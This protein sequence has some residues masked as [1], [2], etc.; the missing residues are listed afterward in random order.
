MVKGYVK[1]LV[2][3]E[4]IPEELT[5]RV[6]GYD[7]EL[8]LEEV[9][10]IKDQDWVSKTV[11]YSPHCSASVVQRSIELMEEKREATLIPH[12]IIA[13][14]CSIKHAEEIKQMYEE[15]GCPCSMVHSNQK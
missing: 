11:A 10:E 6:A 15:N 2:K 12:K 9:L 8:T 13:V 7:R 5:F 1:Q 4:F 3:K 14:A